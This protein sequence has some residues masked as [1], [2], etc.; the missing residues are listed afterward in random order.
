[1]SLCCC[2]FPARPDRLDLQP[3]HAGR[4][5]SGVA[6]NPAASLRGPA[7]MQQTDA[8]SRTSP[9]R[10]LIAHRTGAG[11]RVQ[12]SGIRGWGLWAPC[13][14]M[15]CHVTV[16]KDRVKGCMLPLL[17]MRHASGVSLHQG[18]GFRVQGL[19]VRVCGLL[20]PSCTAM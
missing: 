10:L 3:H 11:F 7:S 12:G 9:R 18:S 17:L 6:L 16:L 2:C 19:G 13:T 15:H 20:A 1:M 5:R 8:S 14:L 4:G